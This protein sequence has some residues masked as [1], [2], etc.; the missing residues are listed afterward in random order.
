M[1]TAPEIFHGRPGYSR[2]V[3]LGRLDRMTGGLVREVLVESWL[4]RAPM[5]L[6]AAHRD[7][8]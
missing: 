4:C 6:A 8:G 1:R 5:S 2:K 3:V 7:L